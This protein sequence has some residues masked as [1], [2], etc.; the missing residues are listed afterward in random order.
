[1]AVIVLHAGMPK[2]GSTTLQLWLAQHQP[3][4]AERGIR[5]RRLVPGEMQGTILAVPPGAVDARS[6]LVGHDP[7]TRRDVVRRLCEKIAEEAATAEMLVVTSEAYEVF[8]NS[9]GW[10]AVLDEFDSLASSH[11][12]RVAYYVRPQH[13]WLESAWLQWGFRNSVDPDVW[14]RS[15]RRRLDYLAT[16]DVVQSTL[17]E[18]SFEMR[19]FRADLLEGGH[20]VTDFAR[21][22]LG[23]DDAPIDAV[24]ASWLNKSLPVEVAMLLRHAPPGAFWSEMRDNKRLN[25]LKRLIDGWRLPPTEAVIRARELLHRYAYTTFEP[26]NQQLRSRLGWDTEHFI[27]PIDGVDGAAAVDLE[28]IN[29]LLT[30]TASAAEREIVFRALQEVLANEEVSVGPK[31]PSARA[32]H[33]QP[34][35]LTRRLVNLSRA[36]TR[37]TAVAPKRTTSGEMLRLRFR[38]YGPAGTFTATAVLDD[39]GPDGK[40]IRLHLPWAPTG[41]RTSLVERGRSQVVRLASIRTSGPDAGPH[42]GVALLVAGDHGKVREHELDRD[43]NTV[44]IVVERQD[45]Q[46]V[47]AVKGVRVAPS[48]NPTA[49]TALAR[50]HR[51]PHGEGDPRVVDV[52]ADV[53]L[54]LRTRTYGAVVFD[55]NNDGWP[56]I[57][58]GR[59]D[60]PAYLFRNRGGRFER[61]ITFPGNVDRH[62]PAA[63]DLTGNGRAD[64]FCV[65]GGE[66]GHAAKHSV[67]ELWIQQPD[68][69]FVDEGSQPGLSDPY[70]RGRE[71]LLF[72]ATGDGRLDILIG[73]VSPRSDGQPSPNRLF[74]NVGN[75]RFRPAPELGLDLEYSVGGAGKPGSR[76]GGGNWPMGRLASIDADG[77][78]RHDVLMCAKAPHDETQSVHLF[79]NDGGRG[80]HDITADAGLGGLAA[81]DCAVADLTGDGRPDLVIVNAAGLLICVNDHGTFRIAHR[82]GMDNAFRVAVGDADGDG[83]PDIYVMRTAS[84]PGPDIADLLL[85]SRGACDDY[86]R[87]TLPTVPG[88]VRDDAVYAIDYDRDGRSE[89]LVLHGHSLHPAPIQL[90]AL[91]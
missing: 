34:R 53:G 12:V 1:M 20:V 46:Q 27:P 24:S 40:P 87:I 14:I 60:A 76:H 6:R 68:G 70:G 49:N 18:V 61:A 56:D 21:A 59:H 2:T 36:A 73:N 91:R 11:S 82:V 81:R 29:T 62:C 69:T 16:L 48:S 75:G 26:G 51:P 77:S 10:R 22:F 8:F 67:N 74:V 33:A 23:I 88:T 83:H 43:V 32:A 58:L 15:Q 28:A 9:A 72:D 35:S 90:I 66:S 31:S 3:L 44:S 45:P 39:V 86:E 42:E 5:V 25:S 64:I 7:A 52:A 84:V 79:R 13:A 54:D 57:F 38:N 71:A 17:S 4:L 19:P 89:F 63:G 80:F 47:V 85:L 30:S 37:L 55:A 65:V 41:T 50:S 78:G